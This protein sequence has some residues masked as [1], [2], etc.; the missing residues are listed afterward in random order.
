MHVE[1]YP[2]A[3]PYEAVNFSYDPGWYSDPRLTTNNRVA[4][5]TSALQMGSL[6]TYVNGTRSGVCNIK[7]MFYGYKYGGSLSDWVAGNMNASPYNMGYLLTCGYIQ[8]ALVFT[9]PSHVPYQAGY[10]DRVRFNCNKDCPYRLTLPAYWKMLGGFQARHFTH[11]NYAGLPS[12]W[13]SGTQNQVET[14]YAYR[15]PPIWK[16]AATDYY[17]VTNPNITITFTYTK[18]AI[19]MV[20]GNPQFPTQRMLGGRML[21]SDSFARASSAD[22]SGGFAPYPEGWTGDAVRTHGDGYNVLYGD[23]HV[24][25]YGDAQQTI[26]WWKMLGKD[27]DILHTVASSYTSQGPWQIFHLFDRQAKMDLSVVFPKP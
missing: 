12:A 6:A 18:P 3:G 24:E 20:P 19:P 4:S 23:A 1:P 25:W 22:G 8:D 14:H 15:N 13:A 9:C 7:G 5:K 21:V 26:A 2:P 27:V 10:T 16:S 11:G 17:C